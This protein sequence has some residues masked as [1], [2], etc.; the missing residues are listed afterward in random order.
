M[1]FARVQKH[2]NQMAALAEWARMARKLALPAVLTAGA[3]AVP[4]R[5]ASAAAIF[6]AQKPASAYAEH[7]SLDQAGVARL[8][9][10]RV[11]KDKSGKITGMNIVRPLDDGTYLKSRLPAAVVEALMQRTIA[12]PP[13]EQLDFV[14]NWRAQAAVA[15]YFGFRADSTKKAFI[16]DLPQ[17]TPEAPAEDVGKIFASTVKAPIFSSKGEVVLGAMRQ[18]EAQPLTAVI[19]A[20]KHHVDLTPFNLDKAT[21]PTGRLVIQIPLPFSIESSTG[22]MEVS[23]VLH[24]T[25]SQLKAF[26]TKQFSSAIGPQLKEQVKKMLYRCGE[27]DG[28]GD[29]AT[30]ESSVE[31]EA[32]TNLIYALRKFVNMISDPEK[33]ADSQTM[34]QFTTDPQMAGALESLSVRLKGYFPDS[35]IF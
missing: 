1:N 30:F 8:L 18:K 17:L 2:L 10:S 31:I 11:E 33:A 19:S 24:I 20:Q 28:I 32:G 27:A 34:A 22:T 23:C 25:A 9:S 29:D 12:L 14:M 3:M 26:R 6:S 16:Y 21:D 4:A 13:E 5:D 7:L 35:S 15:M